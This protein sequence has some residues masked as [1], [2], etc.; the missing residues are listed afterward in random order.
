MKITFPNIDSS[1]AFTL[2]NII[3]QREALVMP[4]NMPNRS[5]GANRI[6]DRNLDVIY[7][8]SEFEQAYNEFNNND[9]TTDEYYT[10]VRNAIRNDLSI[11]VHLA[12]YF[13]GLS[14]I[15]IIAEK[16]QRLHSKSIYAIVDS[17][18]EYIRDNI[19]TQKVK[20][21]TGVTLNWNDQNWEATLRSSNS[22]MDFLFNSSYESLSEDWDYRFNNRAYAQAWC[23]WILD[24]TTEEDKDDV[25]LADIIRGAQELFVRIDCGSTDPAVR[26]PAWVNMIN[27]DINF[28]GTS[29]IWTN[30]YL[31][32]KINSFW[33]E[34]IYQLKSNGDTET[35]TKLSHT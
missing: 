16:G 35:L 18:R 11:E 31:R 1:T 33:I 22:N 2:Y 32:E 15:S 25:E 3:K 20:S 12:S 34:Y 4:D 8:S 24:N 5:F 9:A 28:S 30:E 7:N 27:D 29:M 21:M 14:P 13:V 19:M 6:S 26:D 10:S 17:I 23:Q